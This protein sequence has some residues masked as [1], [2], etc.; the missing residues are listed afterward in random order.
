MTKTAPLSAAR[1]S[2]PQRTLAAEAR[3][4]RGRAFMHSDSTPDAG[5]KWSRLWSRPMA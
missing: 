5:E 4:W 2:E 1:T 3:G